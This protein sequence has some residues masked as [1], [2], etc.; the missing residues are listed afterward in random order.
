[1]S[2]F[3]VLYW[4]TFLAAATVGTRPGALV[5]V[6]F[7]AAGLS[8]LVSSSARAFYSGKIGGRGLPAVARRN[9]FAACG[10]QPHWRGF[11]PTDADGG[12]LQAGA[13]MC[14]PNPTG[15]IIFPAFLPQCAV[16]RPGIGARI[17]RDLGSRLV[18]FAPIPAF[19]PARGG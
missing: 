17:D 13:L 14:M 5:D 15:A 9:G 18:G 6:T 3:K 16:A 10:R 7:A 12:H 11:R 19:S 1:M 8:A 4:T 2:D